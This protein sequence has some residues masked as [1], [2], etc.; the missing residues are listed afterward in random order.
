MDGP[1][2][3]DLQLVIEELVNGLKAYVHW[4]YLEGRLLRIGPGD[5]GD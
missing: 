3:V 1:L 5:P 2:G 4:S